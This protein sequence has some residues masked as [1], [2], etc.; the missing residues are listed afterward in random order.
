M[1]PGTIVNWH[2][3]S[4]IT[5]QV[6]ET[7]DNSPLFLAVSSFDRGPEDLR[8]VTGADFYKLYGSK[9]NFERHGQ[10][11]LQAANII[12][13]GGKLLIKRLVADDATV[14]NTIAIANVKSEINAVKADE[15]DPNGKTLA[16]ITGD[17]SDTVNYTEIL[18]II[19]SV[20]ATDNTTALEVSPSLASGNKYYWKP[21]TSDVVLTLD[22]VISTVDYTEWDGVSDI[23]VVDG[24]KII[25]VETSNAGLA[26]K[27]GF[28]TVTSAIPHPETDSV[29]VDG[30]NTL[31]IHSA[32]GT[33][34]GYTTL[35]VSPAALSGDKYYWKADDGTY[36]ANDDE[37]VGVDF[38]GWTAWD[39]MSEIELE[40]GAEIVLAEFEVNE[41]DPSAVVY[42]VVKG[43]KLAVCSKLADDD[44]TTESITPVI[45][46]TDK[47][48]VDSQ[49]CS[50]KWSA[51]SVTNCKTYDEVVTKAK[52]IYAVGEPE[53]VINDDASVTIS[54]VTKYPMFIAVDNGRG[55]S[56]KSVKFEPDYN[57]SKDMNNM[58]YTVYV[59]DGTTQLEKMTAALNPSAV[60]TDV[61]YGLNQDT[62]TQVVFGTVD[63]MYDKYVAQLSDL[64]GYDVATLQKYDCIY[65]TTNK[66]TAMNPYITLDEASIDF[67]SAY[68]VS[69]QSGTNGSFGDVPFG[70]EA[71][72]NAAV[73]VFRGEFD[74][75]IWDVDT[76]KIV[77]VF[78]ANYPIAVKNAIADFVN[79]RQDCVYF[80]DYGLNV[81]SYAS[82][83]SYYNEIPAEYKTKF[84]ADYYTTYQIKDPETQVRQRVTMMYDFARVMIGHF[85]RG[86]YRPAAGVANNMVLANA[87]DGTIN[88]TPRITPVVNQKSLLDDMKINYAIFEE[89]RC[90]VQ[91][92]YSSQPEYTQ[93]SY[94]NN[95]LGIQE[96][97]RSVRV[98]CPKQRYTFASGSDFSSY[99]DAV[100]AVLKG[101]RSNF[102]EL[103]F[104]YQQDTVKAANKIFYASI[105]FRFNNWA[106]TEVFDIY[107]LGNN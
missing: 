54:T 86:C 33:E 55:I 9:M 100:N 36:P 75:I 38:D 42:K 34:V 85:S 95:V 35:A 76:Y 2:D 43:A 81:A 90:V 29:A 68:G 106:Q 51:V 89:G 92:L 91:S 10:P 97:I 15:A 11:A 22:E 30:L 31:H 21:S 45:P 8:V 52:L 12:N 71:W 1:Y 37:F 13:G 66:G 46:T 32:E 25:L 78:D 74:D 83:V 4:A 79:F 41:D 73:A 27:C 102:A 72:T 48:I 59:Y 65:I 19:S 88:F 7:V 82:I 50:V 16:E 18:D 69:L 77:A 47:Y 40:D 14:A 5:N 23:V 107:A 99:A 87:I 20:G 62:S 39:G 53:T 49:S 63:G 61:L 58:F 44:R 94:I 93:L 56:N 96:V 17:S 80:R 3:E 28:V 6:I 60:F 57:S 67:N 64:S 24:T 98:S 103:K 26:K 101:Y 105:F 104:E 84:I 70:T